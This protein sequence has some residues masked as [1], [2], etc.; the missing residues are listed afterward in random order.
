VARWTAPT[1]ASG[2]SAAVEWNAL[3]GTQ[4]WFL[5]LAL[6]QLLCSVLYVYGSLRLRCKKMGK[7]G[8]AITGFL[9]I[10]A[11]LAT[12][13]FAA[14]SIRFN[15]QLITPVG[16]SPIAGQMAVAVLIAA[17]VIYEWVVST[18]VAKLKQQSKQSFTN[19]QIMCWTSLVAVSVCHYTY[20]QSLHT[21]PR[22][23]LLHLTALSGTL[24]QVLLLVFAVQIVAWQY[25]L[26]E[27]YPVL[28]AVEKF[29]PA[30]Y[31]ESEAFVPPSQPLEI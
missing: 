4:I 6:G 13:A 3:L 21:T 26:P 5:G 20:Y 8:T 11:A 9:L 16:L 18:R 2:R 30:G 14:F 24:S 12:L 28:P 29:G 27:E 10:A 23:D 7:W 25:A 15:K 17:T 19:L 1:T 22:I 31:D